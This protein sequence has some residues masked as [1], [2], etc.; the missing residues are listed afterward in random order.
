MK[1][2]RPSKYYPVMGQNDDPDIYKS[3]AWNSVLV[4][5]GDIVKKYAQGDY[6][7]ELAWH[8][9]EFP[10]KDDRWVKISFDGGISYPLKFQ[11]KNQLVV[12]VVKNLSD[13]GE[14][15]DLNTDIEFSLFDQPISVYDAAKN[16]L[17]SLTAV[18]NIPDHLNGN[19]QTATAQTEPEAGDQTEPETDPDTG[20]Q[21]EPEAGDQTSTSE[22]VD[23][24][25]SWFVSL[26]KFRYIYDDERKV[27]IVRLLEELPS[28]TVALML[29]VG[30]DGSNSN[31][32]A[33][34]S[35]LYSMSTGA[36]PTVYDSGDAN[37]TGYGICNM[38]DRR[39]PTI[40]CLTK[41]EDINALSLK[42][43]SAENT[44]G[45]I[46]LEFICGDTTWTEVFEVTGRE[47]WVNVIEIP[48]PLTGTM[49][50]NRIFGDVN[51]NDIQDTSIFVTNIR[52]E[53]I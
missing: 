33:V 24:E 52:M 45:K 38:L 18:V 25:E 42:V 53:R 27:I 44:T 15:F 26:S 7:N 28:Y 32:L 22:P 2:S 8:V 40:T 1:I 36:I 3:I 46:K 14:D 43:V 47:T 11:F 6:P 49:V 5:R 37:R 19:D 16:G 23:Y 17:I 29:R 50:I 13:L 12:P 51:D 9:A 20:D 35:P 31:A 10:S 48:K 4:S 39:I 41:F 30:V 21:T 34:S